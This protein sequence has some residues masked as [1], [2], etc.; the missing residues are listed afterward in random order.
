MSVA[1]QGLS[2]EELRRACDPSIFDFESTGELPALDEVIGQDRAVSAVSFGIDINS[3]GYHMYALG[4]VGTGKTTT[5]RKFLERKAGEQPVPD[6]WCY[7]NNFDDPD[8]P[9]AIRLPAGKGRE[10]EKD[11]DRLAEELRTE[12]PQAFE[13]EEYEQEQE[14]IQ[15]EFQN[16]QQELLQDLEQEAQSKGFTLLQ[17]PQGLAVVPVSQGQPLTPDKISQLDEEQRQQLEE[18][19]EALQEDLRGRRRQLRQLQR[20]A[21]ERVRELDRQVVGFTVEHLIEELQEKYAEFEA[22]VNFLDRV[23]NDI[24]ENVEAFKQIKQMEQMQQQQQVPAALM[25]G[26]Q[27]PDFDQYRVNLIIDNGDSEGAPV[28]LEANPTHPNLVGRLE[29]QAQ[30]G[31]LVTN[32]QMLKAGAL[33]RANGGY[34]MV[35]AQDVLMKPMA[36]EGL[37]RALKN[38][39]ICIESMREAY[40]AISTRTLDP[41]PIPLDI[42]VIVIGCGSAARHPAGSRRIKMRGRR[43]RFIRSFLVSYV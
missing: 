3:P 28:V 19:Q 42:K 24:L 16:R 17:T 27:E 29:H 20:E 6:D 32:F 30:F 36:W 14:Q 34:L 10:F 2:V 23:R 1:T 37:K 31:A 5:I 18:Q 26:Q 41:E 7:V 25:R 21:K 13:S 33:H 15:E 22:I 38:G 9:R 40:G 35:E 12:V 43:S 4:P 39:E 8:K 11:M